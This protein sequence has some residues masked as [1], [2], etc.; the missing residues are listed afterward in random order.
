MFFWILAG[1]VWLGGVISIITEL[2]RMRGH[3]ISN[4]PTKNCSKKLPKEKLNILYLQ[5]LF[6]KAFN[7]F[8]GIKIHYSN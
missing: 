3:N 1:L 4:D 6:R 8:S 7:F 5:Y 2:I